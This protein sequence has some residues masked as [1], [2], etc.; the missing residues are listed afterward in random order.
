MRT[1]TAILLTFLGFTP[2]FAANQFEE[3][4]ARQA[5]IDKFVHDAPVFLKDTSLKA[6][7]KLNSLKG[8]SVT[9]SPN[10]HVAGEKIEFRTLTYNGLTIYGRVL[11]KSKLSP[12]QIT[13]TDSRWKILNNLNVGTSSERIEQKLG[14]PTK[15]Y[16]GVKQYCGETECVNF[17]A[18][19]RK[20]TK[21][22]LNYY[23]D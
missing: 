10:P 3:M 13:V 21:V 5:V 9:D 6:L 2:S 16:S 4:L 8:E 12:I 15:E 17:H 1:L 11:N 23:S 18:K 22:E 19:E 14:I 20:I 7:R